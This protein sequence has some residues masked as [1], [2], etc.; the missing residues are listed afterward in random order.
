MI[1]ESS[2]P[3]PLLPSSSFS[4]TNAIASFS[5]FLFFFFFFFFFVIVVVVVVVVVFVVVFFFCFF[6]SLAPRLLFTP[7]LLFRLLIF[8]AATPVISQRPVRATYLHP[9]VKTRYFCLPPRNSMYRRTCIYTYRE[10]ENPVAW[11]LSRTSIVR[12]PLL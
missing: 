10:D 3:Q 7:F 4:A 11:K 9:I 2:S 12:Y 5:F 1:S 8:S 6:S